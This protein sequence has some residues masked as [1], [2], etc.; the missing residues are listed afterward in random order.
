MLLSLLLNM[1]LNNFPKVQS[2][3]IGQDVLK[4]YLKR[5][6]M[7]STT[8]HNLE[9]IK[10]LIKEKKKIIKQPKEETVN[11]QSAEDYLLNLIKRCR[12]SA[13]KRDKSVLTYEETTDR[14]FE[15]VIEDGVEKVRF[16]KVKPS[17]EQKQ[18]KLM[19]FLQEA[20]V[21]KHADFT[22]NNIDNYNFLKGLDRTPWDLYDDIKKQYSLILSGPPGT[23]KTTLAVAIAKQ[24]YADGKSVMI[25]RWYNWLLKM[26]GVFQD[27]TIKDMEQ[28][29]R[30]AIHA[31]LL[32]IDE[33]K[34]DKSQ[35][36]TQFEVEQL[37]YLISERHGNMRPFII[38]TN[39][40][41]AEVMGI[42]GEAF[43]SRL[44]DRD[45]TTWIEFHGEDV[46]RNYDYEDL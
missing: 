40:E 12:D 5:N 21:M 22:L 23:G 35:T 32:F 24:F 36:A 44:A 7:T 18:Q 16:L 46:R 42:F 15:W 28:F 34:S 19:E 17:E 10:Q 9:D 41:R 43:Y 29:L 37:M 26:R 1:W 3:T 45:S 30:P 25:K 4:S 27:D 8:T 33:L 2:I 14:P 13:R 38:T 11:K 31:D 39:M 20:G 6:L